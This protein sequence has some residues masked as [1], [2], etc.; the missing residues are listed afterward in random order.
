M[1]HNHAVRALYARL[2]ARGT[3]GDVAL[4]HCMRKL[5]H[6]VFGVWSSNQPF[7]QQYET[8]RKADVQQT[9]ED[10]ASS[11]AQQE[12]A[13]P[14]KEVSPDRQ[15]AG[16][17]AERWS[18]AISNIDAAD[19]SVNCQSSPIDLDTMSTDT[20]S[21]D[22]DTTSTRPTDKRDSGLIDYAYLRSQVTI[23]Q[24]LRKMEHFDRLRGSVQLRGGC[25]FHDSP[26]PESRSFSVNLH[27]NVFRCCNPECGIQGNALDVWAQH[28]GL[29]LY[30][31]AVNLADTFHVELKP[32]GQRR[33]NP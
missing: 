30:E 23:E 31:A 12:T 9:A 18:A 8:K 32:P 3:R 13:G 22:L 17:D 24:V 10:S 4:G 1:R 27:K 15:E 19:D 11:C 20:M 25:P 33:G 14:K 6:Q 28:T 16:T 26:N 29:C 7:D 2:R 5:L 21:T